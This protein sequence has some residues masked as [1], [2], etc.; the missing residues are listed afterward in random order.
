MDHLKETKLTKNNNFFIWGNEG[1]DAKF[2]SKSEQICDL[3]E[4]IQATADI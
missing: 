2:M 4:C 1:L 3:N